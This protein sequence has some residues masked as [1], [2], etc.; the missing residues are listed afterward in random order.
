MTVACSRPLLWASL[1][2]LPLGS[3][4]FFCCDYLSSHSSRGGVWEWDERGG[5]LD[6]TENEYPSSVQF[7]LCSA[8]A[9]TSCA[10]S[11]LLFASPMFRQ[12]FCL[13]PPTHPLTG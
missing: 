9:N 12:F 6:S 4:L 5:V 8:C 10:S 13:C 2:A 7:S 11:Q 1:A 3:F